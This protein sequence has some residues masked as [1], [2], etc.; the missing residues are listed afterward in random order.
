MLLDCRKICTKCKIE[1]PFEAFTR[2]KQMKDGRLSYCTACKSAAAKA[3]KQ[4]NPDKYSS[5]QAEYDRR[6][7]ERHP[8]RV[9]DVKR[10]WH[11]ENS[12]KARETAA[13]WRDKNRNRVR[14]YIRMANARRRA[15]GGRNSIHL[16]DEIMKAQ[17]GMCVACKISLKNGYH[18]DHVMPIKLGGSNE[19]TNLQL[20]CP[21]CNLQKKARHPVDF[22]Q[23]RGFLL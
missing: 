11:Q 1:K 4:A 6:Y 15:N 18:I 16:V 10:K 9:R 12:E 19:R 23:S 17:R 3:R 22:M 7:I 2:T 21:T 13:K 8:D 14:L 20:L 5:K